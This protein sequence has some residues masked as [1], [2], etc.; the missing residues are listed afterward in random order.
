MKYCPLLLA[1]IL[2][3]GGNPNSPDAKVEMVC[4]TDKCAWWAA[5]GECA[6]AAGKPAK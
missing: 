4:I 5:E 6:I 2:T 1:A 3:R